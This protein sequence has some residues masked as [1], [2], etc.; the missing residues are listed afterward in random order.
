MNDSPAVQI[1][2]ANKTGWR[3]VHVTADLG[4][5]SGS[6][7]TA[8]PQLCRRLEMT[9]CQVHLVSTVEQ[10]PARRELRNE[11]EVALLPKSRW[12]KSLGRSPALERE[13]RRLGAQAD[14]FH[15]HGM[16]RLS[17]VRTLREARRRQVRA[18][19]SPLGT[20]ASAAL[21]IAPLRKRAFWT[22]WQRPA[23]RDVACYHAASHTEHDQLRNFG[24][25]API[26]VIPLGVDIPP[27]T[28][29]RRTPGDGTTVL[30][31]GR[32]SRIKN[33]VS[34]IAAWRTIQTDFLGA[35]LRIVGPDD[36]GHREAVRQAVQVFGA[37]RVSIEHEVF[38]VARDALYAASD[39]VVL[40]SLSESFG[41][42]VPEALAAGRPVIA[43]SNS[44]WKV[45]TERDCGWCVAPTV[46]ALAG[47]LREALSLPSEH[48]AEMGHRGRELAEEQ[49]SW[50]RSVGR[51]I[52]LYDW[53]L[54]GGS[55]PEFV[56]T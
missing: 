24:V 31:L 10:G 8:L 25:T 54:G 38:G 52:S 7:Y 41:L 3:I 50:P 4:P 40:P 36:R 53:V 51:F 49:F 28:M 26:A 16:W 27:A 6:T 42:V 23:L 12:G 47:I 30:F 22:V 5:S 55:P 43:T 44:P 9:G 29:Q 37:E 17:T 19:A 34:L 46:E 35:R 20:F 48:L 33:L 45:L 32:I 1:L 56:S 15:V 14:L 11:F 18:I 2:G 21:Q 13:V 39:L